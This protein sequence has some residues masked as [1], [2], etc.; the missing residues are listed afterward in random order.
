MPLRWAR[1][2]GMCRSR[3]YSK[4]VF[5]VCV[6]DMFRFSSFPVSLKEKLQFNSDSLG[7]TPSKDLP[8]IDGCLGGV[9]EGQPSNDKPYGTKLR[10]HGGGHIYIYI[11]IF[12]FF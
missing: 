12:V 4:A 6:F 5:F 10:R 1:L 2:A 8:D 11:Y 3:F 9:P 7:D